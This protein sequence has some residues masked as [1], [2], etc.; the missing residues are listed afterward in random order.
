MKYEYL[1][2]GKQGEILETKDL[3]SNKK[4]PAKRKLIKLK[5]VGT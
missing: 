2:L 1:D 5:N 4:V 3:N